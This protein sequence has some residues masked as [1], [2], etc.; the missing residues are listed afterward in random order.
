MPVHRH[1]FKGLIQFSTDAELYSLYVDESGHVQ[2]YRP[3]TYYDPEHRYFVLGGIISGDGQIPILEQKIERIIEEYF[4]R[5]ELPDTFKLSY[6]E[7]RNG[8]VSPYNTL[9]PGTRYVIANEIFNTIA[10]SDCHLIS[11]IIDLDYI[12]R[13]YIDKIPQRI[14]ALSFLTE[15]FQYFLLEQ[16]STGTIIHEYVTRQI[17][18]DMQT[19]YGRLFKTH[20]LPQTVKFSSIDSRI[21]F[22]RVAEEPILQLSDF[23]AYSVLIRAKTH[24]KKQDRWKSVSHKYYNLDHPNVFKRGNCS[25]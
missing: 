22:A 4:V 11:C 25:L 5:S 16:K 14:L 8:V 9:D 12:Y 17:N 7:L 15:R 18:R 13:N 10:N 24:G 3:N 2:N 23:F 20:N 6:H 21:K 19:N 1:A